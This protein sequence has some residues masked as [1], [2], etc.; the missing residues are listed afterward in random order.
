MSESSEKL[1]RMNTVVKLTEGHRTYFGHLVEAGFVGIVS[2]HF[3][4]N[5]DGEVRHW[6]VGTD[7]D[8]FWLPKDKLEV[9]QS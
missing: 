4:V 1:L 9:C 7:G 5:A 2:E 3:V 8:G 6:V